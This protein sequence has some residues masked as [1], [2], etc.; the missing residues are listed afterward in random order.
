MQIRCKFLTHMEDK[1]WFEFVH[2]KHGDDYLIL[3]LKKLKKIRKNVNI[4]TLILSSSGVFSWTIWAYLPVITSIITALIQL[5]RLIENQ[6]IPVDK[7]IEQIS[8][9]RDMYFDHSNKLEKL[10]IKYSTKV[11]NETEATECFF[12]LREIAKD[13]KTLNNKINIQEIIKL[14]DKADINTVNYLNQYHL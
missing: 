14:Q 13:I 5:F 12:E 8:K 2:Y 10:W 4:W 7:D 6:I 3:Y 9:L 1:I 11:I